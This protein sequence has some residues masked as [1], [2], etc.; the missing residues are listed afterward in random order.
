[1]FIDV[2]YV[3]RSQLREMGYGHPDVVGIFLIPGSD[4]DA[5]QRAAN[6]KA[7][8]NTFAALTELNHFS[9]PDVIFTARYEEREGTLT[10][11]GAPFRRSVVLPLPPEGDEPA[12]WQELGRAADFLARDLTSPLGRAADA[13]RNALPPPE[14]GSPLAFQTF[15][16]IRLWWPRHDLLERASRHFCH[17][18]VQK[19]AAKEVRVGR[20]KIANWVQEQWDKKELSAE[21]QIDR[22]RLACER[23]LGKPPETVFSSLHEPLVP[24]G[25][26]AQPIK[27]AAIKEAAEKINGLLGRPTTS[28]VLYKPGLL[29]DA[30]RT[31]GEALA[32]ESEKKLLDTTSRLVEHPDF[33]LPGAEESLRAFIA[34]IDQALKHHDMLCQE[35]T[36]KAAVGNER[37]QI[38]L[39]NVDEIASS[40]RRASQFSQEIL[41]LIKTYP[42]DRYQSMILRVVL[43]SYTSMR[44]KLADQLRE[45]GYC[46]NRLTELVRGFE[47]VPASSDDRTGRRLL[48]VGAASIDEAVDR[49]VGAVSPKDLEE[50]EKKMHHLVR[51][52]F[53]GFMH[54]CSS[55]ASMMKNLE[56]AMIDEGVQFTMGRLEGYDIAEMYTSRYA[57]DREARN[58]L[59]KT[60][61]E[62][63]PTLIGPNATSRTEL[64]VFA[65]PAGPNEPK[66]RDLASRAVPEAELIPCA[67]LD[68]IVVYREEARLAMDKL[69]LLK[70][71][72]E[73]YQAANV[74]ENFT[75]HARTDIEQWRE[76]VST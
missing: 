1:M 56:T 15:G 24:R 35:L 12:L 67:T 75:T 16:M 52:Q 59:A 3:I 4:K 26:F 20:D 30:I 44:G 7:V 64:C 69:G 6:S 19:W 48:P 72:Q 31:E 46:R 28:A 18:I 66:L 36:Q 43:N 41:E 49:F 45:I 34:L 55:P 39:E 54:V 29:E 17:A 68:D 47:S 40:G 2:A 13:G 71:G 74:A 57:D 11:K 14:P 70:P 61:D 63:A 21:A 33:L 37:L 51:H 53:R 8:A 58:M 23:A 42:R 9:A 32:V 25:W 38:L 10:D 50:L 62:A 65:C 5:Q 76:V 73:A 60:F 22:V 27:P